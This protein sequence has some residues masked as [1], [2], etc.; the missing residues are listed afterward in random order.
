MGRP[1]SMQRG[2]Q[3]LRWQRDVHIDAH[4]CR[5]GHEL[6]RITLSDSHVPDVGEHGERNQAMFVTT[7]DMV[8]VCVNRIG[9]GYSKATLRGLRRTTM[10]LISIWTHGTRFA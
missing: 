7:Q 4:W 3:F 2:R 10:R 1:G 9:E 8:G 5:R 6:S